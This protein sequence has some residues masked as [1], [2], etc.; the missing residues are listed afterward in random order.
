MD[1]LNLWPYLSGKVRQ[2]PRTEI[3]ADSRPVGV[4]LKEIEGRKWKLFLESV[5][6]ADERADYNDDMARL[7]PH[8]QGVPPSNYTGAIEFACHM[9][10]QYPNGTVSPA[11]NSSTMVGDGLLYDV[12]ADPGEHTNLREVRPAVL[13]AMSARLEALQPSF[14]NPDRAGGSQDKVM[15]AA[16]ARGGYWGPFLFP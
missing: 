16:I 11:C 15:A 3:F 14:F 12:D 4:L 1:S 2:S 13:Q 8:W 9:G 10:P 5:S 7:V 6:G